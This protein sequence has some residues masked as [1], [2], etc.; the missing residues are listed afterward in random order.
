MVTQYLSQMMRVCVPSVKVNGRHNHLETM[1]NSEPTSN[2]QHHLWLSVHNCHNTFQQGWAYLM[3]VILNV[4]DDG[5]SER[6]WWWLFWEYP[7]MVILR[8]PGDGYSE[9]TWWWLF[10]AYLMMVILSI[11]DEGYSEHTWWRLFWA[12]LMKVIPETYLMMVIL[13]V[14]DEGYS[15]NSSCALN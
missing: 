1:V 8:V 7:M 2:C 5:Y 12:Y 15:R 14:P 9:S 10:W 13:N 3:M 6:T 4:P 11:P